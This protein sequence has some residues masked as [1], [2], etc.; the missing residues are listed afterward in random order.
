MNT[1]ELVSAGVVALLLTVTS[2]DIWAR[3]VQIDQS[4]PN[5]VPEAQA[6]GIQSFVQEDLASG[7]ATDLY[8]V[9][10]TAECIRADVNDAGPVDDTRF[11]VSINGSSPG[12][13]GNASAINPTGG[14]SL[15]AEVCSGS[16]VNAARRAYVEFSEVN[17]P[18]PEK[19]DSII[20]C[21]TTTGAL[22]N[23]VI[24]KILDQ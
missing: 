13:V 24:V 5:R 10:C 6:V 8:R 4:P 12:F 9:T 3:D 19:Y 18:G 22:I 16:H 15:S 2:T 11:K 1:K 17:A 21:R 23:P 20:V 7:T 14:L